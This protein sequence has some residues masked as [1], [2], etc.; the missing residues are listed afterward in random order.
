MEAADKKAKK[1]EQ[2]EEE[3][4]VS[5]SEEEEEEEPETFDENPAMLDK[6]KTA[7]TISAAALKH[8]AKLCVAGADIADI[9]AEGDKKIDDE[10]ASVLTHALGR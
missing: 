8:V 2:E 7:A 3:E 9:C 5:G 6:Y 1:Q 4:E 10:V